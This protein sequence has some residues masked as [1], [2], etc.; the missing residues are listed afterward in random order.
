MLQ[1]NLLPF[2]YKNNEVTNGN[3]NY[4]HTFVSNT[5]Q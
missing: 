4:N 2:N 3:C 5:N 1:N